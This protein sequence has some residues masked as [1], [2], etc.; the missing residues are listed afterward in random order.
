M[1]M[2]EPLGITV[3]GGHVGA[4]ATTIIG[5]MLERSGDRPV[6]AVVPDLDALP[7]DPRRIR[8]RDHERV[9][10]EDGSFCVSSAH[11][12]LPTLVSLLHA[13]P[14]PERVIIDSGDHTSPWDVARYG[15]LPGFSLVGVVCVLPVDSAI[16]ILTDPRTGRD[17]RARL[18]RADTLVLT[19]SSM[20]LPHESAR[21]RR[22]VKFLV[23][24]PRV[25]FD[26][27][28]VNPRDVLAPTPR[29]QLTLEAPSACAT[30]HHGGRASVAWATTT[31][32]DRRALL[33]LLED[34]GIGIRNVTGIVVLRD[35][36]TVRSVV[37][38][39]P[40]SWRISEGAAWDD[41]VPATTLVFSG[42][43]QLTSRLTPRSLE[44]L[45]SGRR[46]GRGPTVR[47]SLR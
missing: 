21:L 41:T 24:G 4:R 15:Q 11:G 7:L 33:R 22:Q 39:Q 29:Q 12:L 31:P 18:A 25:M 16:A 2:R 30:L 10:L 3:V 26:S 40:G 45:V 9:V 47:Q 28:E 38:G 34:P 27:T 13:S 42:P 20:T 19:G 44:R 43:P 46:R 8:S 14:Q 32:V 36:P 35:A 1:A 37:T 6:A 5:A 23:P 17:T